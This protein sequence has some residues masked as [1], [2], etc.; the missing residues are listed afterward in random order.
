VDIEFLSIGGLGLMEHL[1]GYRRAVLVD[2]ITSGRAACGTVSRFPLEALPDPRCGHSSSAH[3]VSL[4]NALLAG[5]AAGAQLPEQI[6]VVAIEIEPCNEFSE[7]L[8][9]PVAAAVPDAVRMV[10]EV[11]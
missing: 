2:A 1:I 11:L 6:T 7:D 3:D 5:R 8:T 9:P 10:L 4:R